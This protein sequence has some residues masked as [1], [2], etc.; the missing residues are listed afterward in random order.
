MSDHPQKLAIEEIARALRPGDETVVVLTA[1]GQAREHAIGALAKELGRDIYRVDLSCIVSKFI[2]E[3]EKNLKRVFAEA[4]RQKSI[5]LLDEADALFGK[6]SEVKDA[7]D[8]FANQEV[9]YLL[10]RIEKFAGVVILVTNHRRKIESAFRR[11][12]HRI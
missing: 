11:Q 10:Q 6:R 1:A 3:T 5:L 7:H 9:N 12:C 2:G 8:R 4:K